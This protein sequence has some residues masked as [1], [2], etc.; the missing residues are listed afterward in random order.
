MN[1]FWKD[2][3]KSSAMRAFHLLHTFES[4]GCLTDTNLK[5]PSS[6]RGSINRLSEY[7]RSLIKEY[8]AHHQ[9]KQVARGT[10]NTLRSGALSFF[11]YLQENGLHNVAM[12]DYINVKGVSEIV[13]SWSFPF[14]LM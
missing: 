7:Y 14:S 8:L 5:E 13:N 4:K 2:K 11:I 9:L 10:L 1:D 6:D 12:L 3:Q